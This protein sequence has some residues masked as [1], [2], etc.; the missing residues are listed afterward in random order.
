VDT[1]TL[2][3][4]DN[5]DDA[6]A[7]GV[8]EDKIAPILPEA[9]AETRTVQNLVDRLRKQRKNL[10]PRNVSALLHDECVA[11]LTELAVRCRNL[12]VQ[13]RAQEIQREQRNAARAA[14]KVTIVRSSG[15]N[16]GSITP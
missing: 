16:V 5:L 13:L 14:A 7:A 1:R 9:V 11:A 10:G 6:R 2:D 3:V 4:Y 12:E 8:P 15:D